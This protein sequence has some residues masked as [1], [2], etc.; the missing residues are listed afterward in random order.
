M[1][2]KDLMTTEVV[3]VK[4]DTSVGAVADALHTNGFSGVPVV[5]ASG[6]TL[7]LITEKELFSQDSKLYLPGYVRI[8]QETHFV[9]GGHKELPY[10]AGQLTRTKASD[11][12]NRDVFFAQPDMTA[13]EIAEAF[14][15]YDQNPIPVT[16]HDNKLLGL[17][18][19]SDL[20]K[21]LIPASP[22]GHN[23]RL[24]KFEHPLKHRR[25][26]DDELSYVQ[27]DLSSRFAYVARARANVW[28][29]TAVVLFIVGFVVGVIYVADPTIISKHLPGSTAQPY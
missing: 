8:L 29:T 26:V 24:D 1:L 20:I 3:T 4:P 2:V 27:H 25:P 5:D 13:E 16:D 11:I 14:V 7:G 22:V 18:S 21:L 17:M 9:I 19:R 12:M 6:T 10:V 28:V 23:G 15:K